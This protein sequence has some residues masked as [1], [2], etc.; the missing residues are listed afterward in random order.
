MTELIFVNCLLCGHAFYPGETSG[1]MYCPACGRRFNPNLRIEETVL[2]APPGEIPPPPDAAATKEKDAS[3][4]RFGDY[5]IIDEIA[6]GGMGVVYLARHRVLKRVVALKVLRSGDN[7]STEERERLLR[8]AKA[9]AGLSHPNIVPIHEF[10]IFQGQPYFTMDFIDGHPLDRVLENGPLNTREA[11]EI[12][13]AVARAIAYAHARGIIHRDLKPANIIITPEG[14]PMITDFGLAVEQTADGEEQRRMTM[15][16]SVMGTIPYAPPEQ[17][18]GKIDQISERSDVYAMGAVLYEM[19]TGRPPFTGFTQ[20]ELMRRVI[21]QEPQPPR[22]IN[23]K[24]HRDV[25]TIILKCLEKDPRRRYDTAKAFADDCQSFLKGEVITARPAT[26]GY[27]FRR[28]LARRPLLTFLSACVLLLSLAIW[29]GIVYFQV[30]AKEKEATEQ[31]LVNSIARAE[32]MAIEKEETEKQ[33]RR[34]WRTEYNIN[35][36]YAFRFETDMERASRFEIP[37]LDMQQAKLLV[38]PPRLAIADLSN[39]ENSSDNQL[40]GDADLGF[41]FTFQRD[42]RVVLRMQTPAEKIG[43]LVMM[44]DIDRNFRPHLGSTA[45]RFGSPGKPGIAF[46]RSETV[47]GEDPSFSLRPSALSELVVERADNRI[48][49]F[50]DGRPVLDVEDPPAVFNSDSGRITLD[51]IDGSLE[52]FDLSVE[53]RGMSRSQAA[54]LLDTANTMAAQGRAD[55]SLSLYAKVLEEPTGPQNRLRALRGY[56]R[57]LWV[58]L[59][60]RE[61][62]PDGIEKA[63]RELKE[64]LNVAGRTYPGEIEYLEGLALSFNLANQREGRQALDR[65][66]R[67]KTIAYSDE[68]SDSTEYGDLARLESLFVYL[69]MGMLDEAARRFNTMYDDGTTERLYDRFGAELGAGGQAA[70]LLEKADPLI[71]REED[72]ELASVLLRAAAAIAPSSRECANRFHRLGK[73]FEK[74]GEEEKAVELMHWAERLSPD[75]YRPYI[76]EATIHFGQRNRGLADDTLERAKTSIPQ[77]LELQLGIARIYLEDA[78]EVF[79]NP[80]KA[81]EAARRALTL[82]QNQSPAA[83]ELLA[84]ALSRQGRHIEALAAIDSSLTLEMTESRNKLKE[85]IQSRMDDTSTNG[86]LP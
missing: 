32:Q 78:P 8:E 72:L 35:F 24:V 58:G 84:T 25:E 9:A 60:R 57:S 47:I 30:L 23:P 11:V 4:R 15:A 67:A 1:H 7:A 80:V 14:R 13:E 44:L 2:I 45:V 83:F 46:Y 51:V 40:F 34:E 16:G 86:I 27:R 59:P 82:S 43:E 21:N 33:V 70:L 5:D 6:R 73:V 42:V 52:F 10:S 20:F 31:A 68:N 41:P 69:R 79:R 63:C 12:I 75:W 74:R 77:S 17:A 66:D 36:D 61:R 56:A 19:V 76:D 18:A 53:V 49:A 81:E 48:R 54:S 37:W 85:T 71:R 29:M 62:G 64:R 39:T 22:N 38:D 65:L 26:I 50:V 3:V 55:L 28:F